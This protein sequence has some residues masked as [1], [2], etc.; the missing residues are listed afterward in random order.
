MTDTDGDAA[1][2]ER[3]GIESALDGVRTKSVP[4]FEDTAYLRRLYEF[5][6]TFD[7][8]SDL[9]ELD[10]SA[11]TV[12]RYMIDA[13]VHSPGS[14]ATPDR[15]ESGGTTDGSLETYAQ[16]V[17][18]AQT[19]S[20]QGSEA[21]TSV[22]AGT[23]QPEFTRRE[24]DCAEPLTTGDLLT[25]GVGLPDDVTLRELVEVVLQAR[26]VHEVHRHLDIDHERTRELL[27]Q[28]NVLDLVVNRVSPDAEQSV[29]FETVAERIREST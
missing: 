23:S 29:T 10:V 26:T 16:P 25:D 15:S 20:T 8:M 17:R 12:R 28:L 22:R 6:E 11:E 3:D 21:L 1:E 24:A 2:C 9:I 14:N 13:G 4:A 19:R 7:Q 27:R 5:S 18:D